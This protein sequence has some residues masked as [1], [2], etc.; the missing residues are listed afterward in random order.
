MKVNIT[1][2]TN[3]PYEVIGR[4]YDKYLK[5][6]NAGDTIYENKVDYQ[7]LDYKRKSYKIKIEFKISNMNILVEEFIFDKKISMKGVRFPRIPKQ[8]NITKCY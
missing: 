8:K 5:S 7:L 4:V 1:N 3:V 6:I 2:K